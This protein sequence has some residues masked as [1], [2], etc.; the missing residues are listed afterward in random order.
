MKTVTVHEMDDNEFDELVLTRYGHD[1][2]FAADREC[3]NDTQHRFEV[4]RK[5][6][7][8]WEQADLDKFTTSGEGSFLARMLL[9]DLVNQQ[10]LP[11]GIYL[12]NVSW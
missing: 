3:G 1:F 12:I 10:V 6:L 7:D 2:A 4:Q 9:K 5:P 11:E 8:E